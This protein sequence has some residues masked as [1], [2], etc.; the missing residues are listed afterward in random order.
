LKKYG[1]LGV[2]AIGLLGLYIWLAIIYPLSPSLAAPRA[3]WASL[4]APSGLNLALHLVIYLGLTL[5]YLAAMR[6]LYP[7]EE[8][9]GAPS[10][11]LIVLI[12]SIWLACSGVVMFVASA[13]ESHDI[14]DYLFRG[15]M[16]TEYHANPLV[17]IPE[18]FGLSIPYTRYLAWRKNVDTYGPVW[19]TSSAAVATG[20]RWVSSW[21]GW[22]D[23]SYPV[24]PKSPE[25]CRLLMVY[26]TGYRLLAVSLTGLS[27]WLIA[28]MVKRSQATLVPLAMIAWFWSPLTLI[29]TAIGGHNDIVMLILV[30][31]SWWLL[32]HQRPFWA[33]IVL[34]LSAHVKLTAFIWLPT[35]ALWIV[36]RYGWR[37]ALKTCLMAAVCGLVLS[38]LL[39]APFGG[40]QTLPRMLHERSAFLTNSPWQVL[41]YFLNE[42]WNWSSES[43][44]QLTTT[45]SNWLSIAGALLIPLWMFGFRHKR[46][47][48]AAIPTEEADQILWRALAAVSLMFLLIGSFWFQH[49]YILWLLAPAVLIPQSRLTNFVLPWLTFGA[50]SS[51]VVMDFLLN[52][53]PKSVSP[54]M[55]SVLPV[56]LLWGPLLTLAGIR[57]ITRRWNKQSLSV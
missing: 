42:T 29:A 13:G 1:W 56:V 34:I 52:S 35:C 28:S 9:Q 57:A 55:N 39:Y 5:L 26:L 6:L 4:V 3:S 41:S 8:A 40:W 44:H 10:R 18:S 27:G 24:C 25:S 15:R 31:L 50:L 30:L 37:R 48:K 49:W 23:D 21:L 32:Q 17:E 54:V 46:W 36:W 12:I 20:V 33:L 11:W 16:M 43:A 14:F 53:L 38:W 7:A 45:L 51:N 47:R 22:W 19:E 2:I